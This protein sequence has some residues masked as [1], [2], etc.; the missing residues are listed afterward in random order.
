YDRSLPV[1]LI[2][3]APCQ[4]FTAHRKRNWNVLDDRNDLIGA[5][6]KVVSKIQPDF[7]VMENVPELLAHKYWSYFDSFRNHIAESGYTVKQGIHNAASFGTPQDRFRAL[8]FASRL[9]FKLP[10][11]LIEAGDYLTVR[12]AIGG[13]PPVKA[14]DSPSEDG[15]HRSARHRASTIEVI[16]AVP[17]N[18]G[19]RPAG[20]G[21]KCLDRV[22]GYYDVYGRLAWDKPSITITHYARNPASGR[23]VHPVQ[24]RG[25]TMRE[26]AR[27]QGFPDTFL[28]DGTFD[29]T[30]RQIGE[31]V[32]PPLATGVASAVRD[33]FQG[34]VD[35][36][37]EE[38]I[39]APVNN[40]YAGVIAGIKARR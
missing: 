28:I 39:V 31:A 9:E 14:G 37:E 18:G 29:D 40:S 19:S 30:F 15:F 32:P 25:L 26:A 35:D 2:G 10:R 20:I 3:C 16:R 11:P 17:P 12:D 5:F 6:A 27:L 13:L 8:I 24:D 34:E 1:V 36:G 38:L 33:A 22:D 7:I 4:G 23:F 21:P